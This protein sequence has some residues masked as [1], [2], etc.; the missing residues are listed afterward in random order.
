MKL[1]LLLII[2]LK[3]SIQITSIKEF[4]LQQ[5]K[6]K[7]PLEIIRTLIIQFLK[8]FGV[9][10][11]MAN[12]CFTST[13]L[14][15]Y[16]L[17]TQYSG[18]ENGDIGDE[19]NCIKNN[20]VYF[21]YLYQFNIEI[22]GNA[23]NKILKLFMGNNTYYW[24]FCLIK[25][26]LNGFVFLF[27]NY[28]KMFQSTFLEF[29]TASAKI[30]ISKKK[31]NFT[32]YTQF[33][34]NKYQIGKEENNSK[35]RQNIYYILL[36]V[37]QFYLLIIIIFTVL[38]KMFFFT[39]NDNNKRDD[40]SD[41]SDIDEQDNYDYNPSLKK[42]SNKSNK[43]FNKEITYEEINIKKYEKIIKYL[44]YF[45]LLDNNSLFFSFSNK[46][47]NGDYIVIIGFI[48]MIIM[49][50]IVFKFIFLLQTNVFLTNDIFKM[51]IYES[52]LFIFVKLSFFSS[53]SWI[54]LDGAVFGFKLYSFIDKKQKI[55]NIDFITIIKFYI[56]LIPKIFVFLII[57][58]FFDILCFYKEKSN[59]LQNYYVYLKQQYQCFKN[60][61]EIFLPFIYFKSNKTNFN[62]YLTQ[63][64]GYTFILINEF[65]CIIILSIIVFISYKLKSKIFDYFFTLVFILNLFTIQLFYQKYEYEEKYEYLE[66]NVFFG[67]KF[68]EKYTYLFISVFFLGFLV[69]NIIFYYHHVISSTYKSKQFL[70]FS[71]TIYI[72]NKINN[73]EILTKK[74]II[75]V[76]SIILLFISC[77]PLF[78]TK[79]FGQSMKENGNQKIINLLLY[80]D[81]YEKV[82][83]SIIFCILL[84]FLKLIF[85]HSLLSNFLESKFIFSFEKIKIVFFCFIETFLYS[86]YTLVKF[87]FDFTYRNLIH[88][89]IG[90]YVVAYFFSYIFTLFLEFPIIKIIKDFIKN[91]KIEIIKKEI[92]KIDSKIIE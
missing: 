77:T 83:F 62:N 2:H 7:Y 26:C 35:V 40:I 73:L 47:Y 75:F 70:P 50:F 12:E 61:F 78:F 89:A 10:E 80:I 72:M 9:D 85:E 18:K 65:Y 56:Y 15:N 74:I 39:R 42:K 17:L 20:F 27:N 38:K 51:D 21:L 58:F 13:S 16:L 37:M 53:I 54:I 48:R 25:E 34:D 64:Y 32:N 23:D 6:I 92:N 31:D 84:V 71:F 76:L 36:Y 52:F 49:Y 4:T 67:Q 87:N 1:F 91:E 88:I 29:N 11:K 14:E 57:Y 3:L 46:Y 43:I 33:I 45:D 66:I 68:Y 86:S 19:E 22:L 81:I 90:L 24:G 8:N 60:P 63:C 44:S 79:Y 5:S 55:E 28:N 69:G 82:I 41:I 30:L 59:I